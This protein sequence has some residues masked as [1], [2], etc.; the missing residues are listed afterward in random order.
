MA[1]LA[2]PQVSAHALGTDPTLIERLEAGALLPSELSGVW[3]LWLVF[4]L[5][6]IQ[7]LRHVGYL[8]AGFA[9]GLCLIVVFPALTIDFS[10]VLLFPLLLMAL[11][12]TWG[13]EM[14]R[15]MAGGLIMGLAAMAAS[16]LFATHPDLAS[17]RLIRWTAII[18]TLAGASFLGGI[19]KQLSLWFPEQT[20]VGLRILSSWMVALIAIQLATLY[21]P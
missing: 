6:V 2:A 1:L 8:F 12:M 19:V 15:R 18:F 17:D 9:A 7:N 21:A 3:T 14:P 10:R 16:T 20:P 5:F 4:A 11:W 13:R